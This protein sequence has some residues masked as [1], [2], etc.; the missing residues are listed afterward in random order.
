MGRNGSRGSHHGGD[1]H[2]R[3]DSGDHHSRDRGS[4]RGSDDGGGDGPLSKIE[5]IKDAVDGVGDIVEDVKSI[6]EGDPMGV[7]GLVSD[8]AQLA[9]SFMPAAF[10][11][12]VIEGGLIAL[13]VISKTLGFGNPNSGED[14]HDGATGLESTGRG[15]EQAYPSSW[16]GSSSSAY[17]NQ[18][19]KQIDRTSTLIEADN[20]VISILTAEA[21]QVASTRDNMDNI[22]TYLG[23]AIAPAMALMA[24][25]IGGEPA[26]L[27]FQA[28]AV[29][30]ATG[31]ASMTMSEMVSN[32]MS[33]SSQLQQAIAQ[34]QQVSSEAK[35]GGGSMSGP[36]SMPG[37]G[38]PN[39]SG[40]GDSPTGSSPGDGAP[41]GGTPSGGGGTP[42]GGGGGTPSSGGGGASSGGSGT[43]SSSGAGATP[44]TSASS[45]SGASGGAS[46]S[47]AGGG[48][49]MLGSL[50]SLL[51]QV[52]QAATQAAGQAQQAATQ[53]AT[54]AAGLAQQA[55]GQGQEG[56]PAAAGEEVQTVGRE[57]PVAEQEGAAGAGSEV[58]GERA[59]IHIAVDFDS[60][61]R[62]EMDVQP[63][64]VNGP[65]HVSL[66]PANP[67]APPRI[68]RE[69]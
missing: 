35:L 62:V 24:I 41:S 44:S 14:F 47:A 59:P 66:D 5:D 56:D 61:R 39:T 26:S 3:S 8:G 34:Y 16:E 1:T 12:P 13:N 45:P 64:Q 58:P 52:V 67:T 37:T 50:G 30:V 19:S 17:S 21:E 10:A 6:L 46:G 65:I 31:A 18:N 28:I 25:P 40:N 38:N 49:G 7:V 32:A 69:V 23:A 9:Q 11:T 15:L 20:K 33:N 51:G 22:A 53:A 57:E 54:Q 63:D 43:P 36:P 60:E 2:N 55:A 68:T 4:N 42:S 27:A 48:A 29:G